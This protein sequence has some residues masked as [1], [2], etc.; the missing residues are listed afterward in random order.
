MKKN[1]R[2]L[3]Y[4]RKPEEKTETK[5]MHSIFNQIYAIY[6]FYNI[7]EKQTLMILTNLWK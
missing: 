3:V 6:S 4:P 5:Y 1:A 7:E 2:L